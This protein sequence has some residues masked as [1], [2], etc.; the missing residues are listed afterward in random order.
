MIL[1][2]IKSCDEEL[3]QNPD[4]IDVLHIRGL[5]HIVFEEYDKAIED[6][7]LILKSNPNDAIA[8][9]MKSDCHYNK[10]ELTLA[11]Q[12]YMRGLRNQYDTE[13]SENDIGSAV[14]LDN[15]DLRD[16]R[17]IVEHEK[18]EAFFKYLSN[19]GSE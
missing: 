11:K 1:E 19:F 7:N 12:D 4:D 16:I 8:Y 15:E 9:Y 3:L 18:K 13:I 17:R 10:G 6:F 5:L 2:F 14:I